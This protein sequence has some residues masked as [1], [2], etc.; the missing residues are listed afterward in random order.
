MLRRLHHQP[1]ALLVVAALFFD[2]DVARAQSPG[3]PAG[4][5]QQVGARDAA[6][7]GEDAAAR[8]YAEARAVLA[9]GDTAQAQRRLEWLV[10]QHPTSPL[11]DVARRDLKAIYDTAFASPAMGV[12]G[13][14]GRASA[15]PAASPPPA[16]TLHLSL[17]MDDL[18]Q[19]AGDRVF[20]AADSADLSPRAHTALQVQAD[21]LQRNP[22]VAITI[23]GHADDRGGA[24]EN[25]LL[26]RRRAE[27]VRLR[28]TDFGIDPERLTVAAFG[29]DRLVAD[30]A[31]ASCAAQNRRA[32]TVVTRAPVAFGT[33]TAK[34]AQR[35]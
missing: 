2:A 30:C 13:L 28:L 29:R 16:P 3:R 25:M 11:A 20:F 15:P 14:A 23:E 18:R 10:A 35:N 21:W 22:G 24:E 32:V 12:L 31:A 34:R 5:A 33:D 8:L 4:I 1:V 27:A 6:V 7:G 17:A 19:K 26:A 9:A